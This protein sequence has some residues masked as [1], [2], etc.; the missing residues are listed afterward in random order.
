MHL[1]RG[2]SVKKKKNPK[3]FGLTED[4]LR[5]KVVDKDGGYII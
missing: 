3:N 5:G 1:L 2:Q 4:K